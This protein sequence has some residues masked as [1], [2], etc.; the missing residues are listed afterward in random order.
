MLT[1]WHLPPPIAAAVRRHHGPH[2]ANVAN[3]LSRMVEL[4]DTVVE[5]Q[6]IAAQPWMRTSEGAPVEVLATVGLDGQAQVLLD[7]FKAEYDTI[8][9]FF[10]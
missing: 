10:A 5:Q 4:A 1:R 8:K 7:S 9:S 3:S 2:A 6:G